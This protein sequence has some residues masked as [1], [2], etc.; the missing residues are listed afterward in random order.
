MPEETRLLEKRD[1]VHIAIVAAIALVVGVYLIATTVL[2]A[3]D[4]VFYIQ[5]AQR[6]INDPA[7]IIRKY[8]PGY[9]FLI[10]AAHTFAAG[11]F[12]G[13]SSAQ[14]WIYSAQAVT[15][16]C[17]LLAL[18]PLYF[19][20]KLLVGA[21]NSFL[22]V[23]ILLFLPYP[24]EYGADVL[25]EWP[26][27]MFLSC[28]FLFL[29]LGSKRGI[30]WMFGLAGL[31]AG[32]GYLIRP[33]CA[34]LVFYGAIWIVIRFLRPEPN[35][36]RLKLLL[37]LL[38]LF[39]GFVIPAGPYTKARGRILPDK[40]RVIINSL[41]RNS[42]PDST[43]PGEPADE[44]PVC[45]QAALVPGDV[46]RAFGEL[47]ESMSENLMWFFVL[48]L[49]TGIYYHFRYYSQPCEKVFVTSFI[50]VNTLMLVLRYCCTTPYLNR[51][52]TLPLVSFTV[53]YIPTGLKIIG[54]WI[55]NNA[56]KHEKTAGEKRGNSPFWF[57]VLFVIGTAICLPKLIRPVRIEKSGFREASEWLKNNTAE[58]DL[59]A[60]EDLRIAFYAE[61][62][63]LRYEDGD[64]VP[65]DAD[66]VV[67]IVDAEEG[68]DCSTA[69]LKIRQ[70]FYVG[71]RAKKRK[72]VLLEVL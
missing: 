37:S 70:S 42:S 17:R 33:V 68:N 36:S 1:I 60:C 11:L 49:L 65:A 63:G 28:G 23:L 15:L 47:A 29:L 22:A 4:G 20:G 55:A 21:K 2:I 41:T 71:R 18:I 48:P 25:R 24:A 45:L 58:S 43:D 54:A 8:P 32:L 52:Y 39:V 30:C 50:M 44:R 72:L 35:M 3:R 27:I 46:C 69:N 13:N 59:I 66:Y 40:A 5:R 51:R 12:G 34:Q 19:M 7:N 38:L 9:P 26:H 67:K 64:S 16:L 56:T 57:Y 6:F 62:K 61:R 14:S 10:L 53:F 31:S